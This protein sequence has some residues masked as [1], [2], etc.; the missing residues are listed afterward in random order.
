[1]RMKKTALTVLLLAACC[2]A[3][4]AR[5]ASGAMSE[6]KRRDLIRLLELTKAADLGAQIIRQ[7]IEELR[8]N[9]SM[10]PEEQR[11]KVLK[12]FEEEML[13]EFSK[14]KVVET[15]LPIYDKFLTA[16]DVKE[17]ISFYETPLGHKLVDVL[18]QIVKESYEDGARRGREAGLRALARLSEEGL[19]NQPPPDVQRDIQTTKPARKGRHVR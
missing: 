10:I 3:A 12:V 4:R 2:V 9:F 15:V 13:K 1:M 19:L 8:Q 7:S 16:E 14:E 18:P 17:M 11:E 5:T 6:E